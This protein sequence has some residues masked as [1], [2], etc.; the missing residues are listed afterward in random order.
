MSITCSGIL[1]RRKLR[2]WMHTSLELNKLN[3]CKYLGKVKQEMTH[4]RFV[5]GL[6]DGHVKEKLLC[7]EK[8][9]LLTAV[10]TA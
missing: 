1:I 9:G 3:M 8:L 6:T 10:G 4:D 2:L 5:F 7:K